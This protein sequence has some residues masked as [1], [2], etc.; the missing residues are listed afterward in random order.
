MLNI[1]N[2]EYLGHSMQTDQKNL[3]SL[4]I[5]YFILLYVMLIF[6]IFNCCFL[7]LLFYRNMNIS[8]FFYITINI[9]MV[10]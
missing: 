3:T 2:N 10:L 9:L 6:F 1:L 8:L 5:V 4:N 7:I